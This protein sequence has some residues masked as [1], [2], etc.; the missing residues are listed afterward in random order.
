MKKNLFLLVISSMILIFGCNSSDSGLNEKINQLTESNATLLQEQKVMGET[1]ADLEKKIESLESEIKKMADELKNTVKKPVDFSD[2]KLYENHLLD[3][4]LDFKYSGCETKIYQEPNTENLIY[5]TK[6]GD[7]FKISNVI[8]VKE[9]GKNFIKGKTNSGIEGFIALSGNPYKDGNFEQIN[10]IEVNGKK[11]TTLKFEKNFL[12]RED[13]IVKSLPTEE[14]ENL[15][16]ITHADGMSYFDSKEITEDYGW[17]KVVVKDVVGWVPAKTLSRDI[18]GPT[19][20][21]PEEYIRFE[22]IDKN[23]I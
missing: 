7:V 13:T 2:T 12:I 18:G 6:A 3:F 9:T 4:E 21:T 17:V 5:T 23:M 15:Y 16:T 20:N 22:L 1:I 10:I 19:L 14:S 8:Y 11:L